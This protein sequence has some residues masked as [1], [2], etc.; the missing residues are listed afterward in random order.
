MGHH[1]KY[2][3]GYIMVPYDL[4]VRIPDF[5]LCVFINIYYASISVVGLEF[6]VGLKTTFLG[7]QPCLGIEHIFNQSWT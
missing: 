3:F 1:I 7:S 6:S 2:S 4:M 5:H